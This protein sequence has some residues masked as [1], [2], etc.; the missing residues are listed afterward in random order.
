MYGLLYYV[1]VVFLLTG[2][3]GSAA[4]LSHA[5]KTNREAS[6][7]LEQQ[8]SS[9]PLPVCHANNISSR[10]DSIQSS[11]EIEKRSSVN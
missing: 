9:L 1:W 5:T 4:A 8:A 10:F 7:H 3:G 11:S 2:T 6:K